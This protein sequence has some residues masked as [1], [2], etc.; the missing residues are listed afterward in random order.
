MKPTDC[1]DG[2]Y[3]ALHRC[4]GEENGASFER[5]VKEW[6]RELVWVVCCLRITKRI[7]LPFSQ[8]RI[9]NRLDRGIENIKFLYTKI[10]HRLLYRL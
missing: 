6:E 3:W 1:D 2:L 10:V 4:I 5:F 9:A 7:V 8:S